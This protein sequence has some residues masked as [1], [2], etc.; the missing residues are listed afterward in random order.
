MLSTGPSGSIGIFDSGLGGLNTLRHL[1]AKLP[2]YDFVYLGDSARAPY[3]PRSSQEIYA[4]SKQ[5]LDF[6][7]GNGCELVIFACN[8]ASS[9]A[10]HLIQTEYLPER[11]PDKKVLGVL[12]PLAEET[13]RATKN[14]KVGI[15]ATEGTVRSNAF[16]REIGKLDPE[17]EIFQQA[18]P[19]LVPL[20]EAGEYASENIHNALEHYIRPLTGQ[21]VDTIILGCTHYDILKSEIEAM[22]GPDIRVISEGFIVAEKLAA[23]LSR[24]PEID[25]KL[26]QGGKRLFYSS[27]PTDT[28]S[29]LGS[30]FFGEPF[31]AEKARL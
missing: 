16:V 13:V 30:V 19:L 23:Y 31:V 22:V 28:F 15:I 24:H 2:T 1:V 27:D 29:T 3:G 12:I 9:D 8:T 4:F 17:I 14:K 21:G 20:I 25:G 7:F 26:A 5:A 10:L 11:Y 6:L 18:A